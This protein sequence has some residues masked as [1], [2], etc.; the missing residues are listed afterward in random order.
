MSEEPEITPTTHDTETPT[1]DVGTPATEDTKTSEPAKNQRRYT[2]LSRHISTLRALRLGGAFTIV[3]AIVLAIMWWA[4]LTLLWGIAFPYFWFTLAILALWPLGAQLKPLKR[5]FAALTAVCTIVAVG[6]MG[7]QWWLIH[8]QTS[9]W[10][11][12]LPVQALATCG[13][14]VFVVSDVVLRGIR[15]HQNIPPNDPDDPAR[16]RPMKHNTPHASRRWTCLL[17]RSALTV[18]PVTATA[19]AIALLQA[20]AAP[21]NHTAPLPEGPLPERSTRHRRHPY[22][23]TR[24]AGTAGHRIWSRRT[25]D[26]HP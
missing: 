3:T 25:G 18:T 16:Y 9:I 22:L 17:R 26:T 23:D 12:L 11:G 4:Q 6:A 2:F 19:T 8:E 20:S 7:Q 13:L 10:I 14:G 15:T 21:I 24:R 1:D 5:T